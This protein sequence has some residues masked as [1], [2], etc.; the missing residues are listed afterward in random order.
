MERLLLNKLE[1]YRVHDFH[2]L[3]SSECITFED[4]L[5]MMLNVNKCPDCDREIKKYYEPNDPQQFSFDRLNDRIPHIKSNLR[6]TCLECNMKKAAE[7]YKPDEN[8]LADYELLR[9]EFF[10]IARNKHLINN[11][12]KA[13]ERQR[14]L[15]TAASILHT[16]VYG[17][18]KK[19][20]WQV[21]DVTPAEP[22]K[23]YKNYWDL[24]IN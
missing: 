2:R 19:S 1:R 15:T 4:A 23:Y 18:R 5:E 16:K 11:K 6:I 21:H 14:Q 3:K 8:Y 9:N 20:S 17:D 13:T 7:Q 22:N 24:Q 12:Q 10:Y